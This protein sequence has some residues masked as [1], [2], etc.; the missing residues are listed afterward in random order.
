MVFDVEEGF[1]TP[2]VGRVVPHGIQPREV[3]L[4]ISSEGDGGHRAYVI[5]IEGDADAAG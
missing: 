5:F 1:S 4:H 2:M 3:F